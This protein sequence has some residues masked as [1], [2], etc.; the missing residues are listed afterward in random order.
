MLVLPVVAPC[1]AIQWPILQATESQL[2]DK[3]IIMHWKIATKCSL[4][5]LLFLAV[6]IFQKEQNKLKYFI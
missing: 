3:L 2:D 4:V 1:H 5:F 6:E